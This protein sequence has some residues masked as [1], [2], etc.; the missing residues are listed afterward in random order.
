[1]PQEEC[2]YRCACDRRRRPNGNSTAELPGRFCEPRT[3]QGTSLQVFS[4]A[5]S[6]AAL[7]ETRQV[8]VGNVTVTTQRKMR[9]S[10]GNSRPRAEEMRR[11]DAR[12]NFAGIEDLG[13]RFWLRGAFTASAPTQPELY[14]HEAFVV[15]GEVSSIFVVGCNVW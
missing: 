6:G 10:R 4:M 9:M 11:R 14:R 5:T 1:M 15:V 13:S 3:A 8:L 2:R 12:F 7:T